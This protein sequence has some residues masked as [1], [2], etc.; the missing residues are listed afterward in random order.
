MAKPYIPQIRVLS[1]DHGRTTLAEQRL[2]HALDKHNLRHYPVRSAFC[3][4][5]TG[6]CGIPAGIVAIEVD[7]VLVWH[8]SEL[9][10]ELADQFCS[11]LPDYL[12]RQLRELGITNTP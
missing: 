8:G 3:H 10:E 5:E 2:R 6:R 7:G 11:G 12:Q 1:V 9:T 4:L